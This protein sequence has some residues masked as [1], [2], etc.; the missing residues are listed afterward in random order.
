MLILDEFQHFIDRD[1][2]QVLK[3][4]TDW[5]KNLILDTNLP[6]ILIGLPEAE[7]VLKFKS[8]SQLS[9]RFANRH[10][11]RPFVWQQDGAEEFRTFLHLIESKLPLLEASNL[12]DEDMAR[13]LYFASDGIVAYIMKLM[14]YG[15]YLAL[16]QNLEKLDLK[17][18]AIAFEKYVHADKPAKVN[19]FLTDKFEL[20]EFKTSRPTAEIEATNNRARHVSSTV[21]ASSI[22]K[23]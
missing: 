12:A 1:S 14:R 22:L 17:L 7:Q 16:Q 3:T 11:L 15:T 13:R 8:H 10:Y 6:I 21:K 2:A 18:L 4:V 9:R 19:P 5:L 20:E 23:G